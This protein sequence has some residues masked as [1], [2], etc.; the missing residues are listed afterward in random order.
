M[1]GLAA[2]VRMVAPY[3]CPVGPTWA[4]GGGLLRARLDTTQSGAREGSHAIGCY[5]AAVDELECG[6]ANHFASA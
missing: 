4:N 3:L 6:N 1:A 2:R 5:L